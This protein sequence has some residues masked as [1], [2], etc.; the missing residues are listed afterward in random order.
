MRAA[1]FPGGK[2]LNTQTIPRPTPSVQATPLL[3][4]QRA[5]TLAEIHNA[6]CRW[7]GQCS[8]CSDLNERVSKL[9]AR[10]G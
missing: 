3:A 6:V 4:L 8:T 1:H 2:A 10:C 7:R 9:E 5:R